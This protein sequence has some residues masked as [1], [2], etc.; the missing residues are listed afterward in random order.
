MFFESKDFVQI[1]VENWQVL[2]FG[3]GDWE[4]LY[5]AALGYFW[6]MW[7]IRFILSRF[8]KP[9]KNDYVDATTVII[10]TYKED[11]EIL[12]ESVNRVLS[13][14][15]DIVSDVIIVTDQREP[16]ITQ[17]CQVKWCMPRVRVIEATP[18][19]RQ[20][21][22]LGIEAATTELV[23]IV[24]SDTFATPNAINALIKPFADAHVG[25][26]VGDQLI[27]EPYKSVVNLFNN[28]VELIKY[29][30]AVP[31]LSLFGQVTVLGGRC[32]AFRRSAVLPLMDSL[33]DEVFFGRQ[34]VSGDDGRLT[35]LLMQAGWRS[36]YQSSA[37]F[38]TVSPPTLHTLSKQRLRWF[39][40][41]C[42]RTI[43]A[44][45]SFQEP[46]LPEADRRWVW[47]R[48]LAALQMIAVWTNS[49]VM[50]V[51]LVG[52]TGS[53]LSGDWAFT[54]YTVPDVLIRLVII[55]GLGMSIRRFIRIYPAI[56][57]T[58]S[59]Y[60]IYVL[61]FPWYLI[62]MWFV[63]LYAILTM[64]QQGWVTR[65]GSGAGGFGPATQNKATTIT[66]LE[67]H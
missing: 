8:Y 39:R 31:A 52:V 22:R 16:D 41:S 28:W 67:A 4:W 30:L 23:V 1:I 60:W 63:R 5:I 34:C 53:I 32:V 37:K 17:W 51:L 61:V 15:E 62:L 12:T 42:R 24:E 59:M 25:G 58:R 7:G 36:V 65:V 29:R 21:V 26:I 6:V 33:V 47:K 27:Y 45:L 56:R 43:R 19:K 44:L 20:A 35:S 57:E 10:P 66:P 49:I 14:S 3:I 2:F 40:N 55:L 38:L 54:G 18:G 64:N 48:P 9:W 46:Y 11:K 13:H 50:G